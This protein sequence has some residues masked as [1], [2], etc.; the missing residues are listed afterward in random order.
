MSSNPGAQV[1]PP[2]VGRHYLL[3][4]QRV[5]SSYP[6]E[7]T[8]VLGTCIAVCLWDPHSGAG[9]MNHYLLPHRLDGEA[10]WRFGGTAI[11]GLIAEVRSLAGPHAKLM[12]KVFGGMQARH[13]TPVSRDLGLGNAK[14][15]FEILEAEHIPVLASDI[16]GLRGRKLIFSLP[17]GEA[18]VKYL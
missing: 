8:T 14:L 12:A 4:G 5:V 15:A 9:G 17:Q 1:P 7:I 13:G 18:L 2:A 3:P 6:Y 10:S 16:G 11:P